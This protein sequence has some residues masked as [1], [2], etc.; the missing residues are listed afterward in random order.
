MDITQKK[1]LYPVRNFVVPAMVGS[2]LW[3]V[4]VIS[5]PQAAYG[6]GRCSFAARWRW[7]YFFHYHL[8]K[9]V[10]SVCKWEKRDTKELFVQYPVNVT[11]KYFL[12]CSPD[13]GR[14]HYSWTQCVGLALQHPKISHSAENI[15]RNSTMQKGSMTL[16]VTAMSEIISEEA[17]N[18]F[19]MWLYTLY[20]FWRS[21][22][23]TG[24]SYHS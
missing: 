15:N 6:A 9:E 3:L 13:F 14:W 16:L 4:L 12:D 18:G 7:K 2:L 1:S 23:I 20:V 22:M 11:S 21:F 19:I 24:E 17:K 10:F 5:A 8:Y